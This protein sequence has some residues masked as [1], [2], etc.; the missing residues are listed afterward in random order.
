MNT[1]LLNG[2]DGMQ[3]MATQCKRMVLV[4]FA[5]REVHHGGPYLL[6]GR[7]E[8][9]VTIMNMDTIPYNGEQKH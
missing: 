4:S 9:D 1:G 7:G 8:K 5:S 6:N 3:V 2:M